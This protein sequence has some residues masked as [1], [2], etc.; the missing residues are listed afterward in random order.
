MR[1]SASQFNL[2]RLLL[3]STAAVMG[4]AAVLMPLSGTAQTTPVA[5]VAWTQPANLAD[6][7]EVVSPAVVKITATSTRE[8]ADNA[9]QNGLPQGL[10]PGPMGELFKKFFEQEQGGQIP[11][12]QP[13]PQPMQALGSGFIIDSNG[14]IV[15][16]NHV[17]DG[18]EKLVVT[19]KDGREFD[20]ELLGVDPKTDLAVLKIESNDAL[21]SVQWGDSEHLRVGDPVFAVGAPYGLSGSVTSGIV[22]ARGRDIGA[23]PYDDF[24]QVD[25]P[26]N[27]GNSGGPLFDANG[28][29]VGVNTAIYSPTGGSVGIGFS[30]PA[31]LA[32]QIVSEIISDGTVERGW[33]GVAIQNVDNDIAKSLGLEKP[34]GA[35]VSN[36]QEDS[37]AAKAGV[38]AGDVIIAFGDKEIGDVG[39]LTLAVAEADIGKTTDMK[40]YRDGQTLVLEPKIA[41][42][43]STNSQGKKM[44]PASQYNLSDLGMSLD[45]RDGRLVVTSVAPDS[46]AAEAGLRE[47]DAVVMVNQQPVTSLS[48]VKDALKQAKETGRKSVLVQIERNDSRRFVA[49]PFAAS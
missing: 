49:V 23:G 9:L 11:F 25:A 30:I 5:P 15:T 12:P 37:P 44:A 22:S 45:T 42:L 4:A 31:Q 27:K 7:I 34:K 26:I 35:I 33:L 43:E 28:N 40:V 2:R 3:G 10:P 16:N 39:D 14:I 48:D 20:A 8:V 36:V 21:P 19:L 32:K 1:K 17:V 41:L 29:V 13:R 24:I 6:L 46:G 38:K 47:G 18:A